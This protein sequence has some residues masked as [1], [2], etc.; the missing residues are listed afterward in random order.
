MA[1]AVELRGVTKSFGVLPVLRDLSIAVED[2]EFVSI[3]G[4]SGCGKTTLLRIVAGLTEASFGD[5]RVCGESP[6]AT[7]RKGN[8]GFCSQKPVLLPW[9]NV[10]RNVELPLELLRRSRRRDPSALLRDLGLTG[11]ETAM[12]RELSGGMQQR[13]N[14]ARALVFEPALL[15]M[16]EPFGAL[17]E[18]LRDRLDFEFRR[19]TDALHQTV[20][21]V[22]HSVFEAAFISD[23][24]IVLG[25]RPARIL[26]MVDV[27][28][29]DRSAQARGSPRHVETAHAIRAL[30]EAA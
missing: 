26:G 21:F 27:Q 16:D 28:L 14:V 15:L 1:I 11:F 19:L 2:G 18:I 3:V 17:D 25:P 24:V 23:R 13:V 9:R 5:V 20:L 6:A 10:R 12:P 4:P 7:R 8:I 29:E 22:T 30:L